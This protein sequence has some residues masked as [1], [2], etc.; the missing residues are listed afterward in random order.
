[1]TQ[2]AWADEADTLGSSH[3][4]KF[5]LAN[6]QLTC[7]RHIVGVETRGQVKNASFH[8]FGKRHRV[9]VPVHARLLRSKVRTERLDD[10][11]LLNVRHDKPWR[12]Q[13]EDDSRA[14]YLT[15]TGGL[16]NRHRSANTRPESGTIMLLSKG[17]MRFT[18][19]QV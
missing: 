16:M 10:S 7:R 15:K 1:M 18:L 4:R 17:Y 5:E 2:P 12:V 11:Q 6:K 9:V 13:A 3:C 19:K 8:A 14:A